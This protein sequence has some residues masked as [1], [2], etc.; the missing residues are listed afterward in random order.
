MDAFWLD[1]KA[2]RDEVNR[3]LKGCSTEWILKLPKEMVKRNFAV[4][5]LSLYIPGLVE[6][7][8]LESFAGH[9]ARAD[10]EIPFTILAFFPG[11]KMQN[12]RS[13]TMEEMVRAFEAA[14]TAGLKNVRLGNTGIFPRGGE[15]MQILLQKVGLGSF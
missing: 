12:Y 10:R 11:Y 8:Q 2:Y 3:W 13:P 1:V 6:T 14:K 7:D 15:E 4:E 9:L 5:V